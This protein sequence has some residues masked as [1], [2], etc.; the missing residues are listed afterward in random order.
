MMP[1][2]TESIYNYTWGGTKSEKEK[3]GRPRCSEAALAKTV[4]MYGQ[5]EAAETQEQAVDVA[6]I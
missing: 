4:S 5:R 1:K 6:C 3:V 2:V